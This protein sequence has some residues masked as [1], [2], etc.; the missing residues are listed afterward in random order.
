MHL[1][2]CVKN[3]PM[4]FRVTG[5]CLLVCLCVYGEVL[6]PCQP[7]QVS[8]SAVSLPSHTFTGQ[9]YSS[10]QLTSI[11]NILLPETDNCHS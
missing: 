4:K 5:I 1:C 6:R 8:S 9:A 2:K 7:N 3:F 11:V 10:K